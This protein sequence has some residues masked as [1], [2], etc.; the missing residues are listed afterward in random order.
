MY[1]VLILDHQLVHVMQIKQ[2]LDAHGGKYQTSYLTSPNG[3]L[4][5]LDF[6]RPDALLLNPWMPRLDTAHLLP[7][8][9][10]TPA[11]EALVVIVL[12]DRDT[13]TIQNFCVEHDL[14]GYYSK[15]MDLTQIPQFLDQ[16]FE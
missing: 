8:I 3:V 13:N 2:A 16:F 12:S 11:F 14:H 4:A 15:H 10:G 9:L 5:K 1:K 7:T 6:E